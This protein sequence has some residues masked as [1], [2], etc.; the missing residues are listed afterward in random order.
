M[1]RVTPDPASRTTQETGARSMAET[2]PA[3]AVALMETPSR[4]RRPLTT[5]LV[6]LVLAVLMLLPTPWAQAAPPSRVD[7]VDTTGSLHPGPLTE[8]LQQI[9]FREDVHVVA[10]SIDV[11]DEGRDPQDD[12]ALNDA[13]LLHARREHPEWITSGGAFWADGLVILA[14]DERN[15]LLGVYAGEDVALDEGGQQAVREAMTGPAQEGDWDGTMVEGARRYADLLGRP[16]YLSPLVGVGALG[17][18][19]LGLTGVGA[20]LAR[21]SSS[22]TTLRRARE[23]YTATMMLASE[24]ELAARTIPRESMYGEPVLRDWESFT[25]SAAEATRLDGQLPASPGPL[26]GISPPSAHLVSQYATAVAQID[27]LDDRIIRA[28]DLL[29]MNHR[30]H[31]AW[32]VETEP[33]RESLARTDEVVRAHPVLADSP[34]ALAVRRTAAGIAAALPRLEQ[35]LDARSITPDQALETLDRMTGDLSSAAVAHQDAVIAATARSAEEERIMRS[36]TAGDGDQWSPTIRSRRRH[37]YPASYGAFF[38]FDPLLWLWTWDAISRQSIETHRTPP[39][40]SGSGGGFSGY[41]GSI[42]G[43]FSGS[44]SSSRF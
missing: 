17:A 25:R 19:V 16:W 40:T 10:L 21:R 42:G 13:V 29:S 14:L 5:L 4:A 7:V 26:W 12:L 39:V 32:Q 28:N 37:Y 11:Q 2:R 35:Q 44:G 6:L 9:D 36:A 1:T 43:G 3:S 34:T 24:T 18:G 27:D 38:A 15:R 30:W 8:R 41:S 31:Q 33:L 22:R 20:A 23:R